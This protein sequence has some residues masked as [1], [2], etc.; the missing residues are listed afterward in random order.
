MKNTFLIM[1][2]LFSADGAFC[3]SGK[4]SGIVDD[5]YQISN[6]A[7]FQEIEDDLTAS[8]IL[9]N[10]ID[11]SETKT[12][13]IGKG[14][15]PLGS[16]EGSM[17]FTGRLDGN[18]FSIRNL[19]IN[20]PM[21][22]DL[23]VFYCISNGAEI[24]NLSILDAEVT[25][26]KNTA[27]FSSI[28]TASQN[29]EV[30]IQNC[31][32]SGSLSGQVFIAGFCYKISSAANG[33]IYISDCS[34]DCNIVGN[35]RIGGFCN[36]VSSGN[37]DASLTRI[38]DCIARGRV[39]GVYQVGGF[40]SWNISYDGTSEIEGCISETEVNCYRLGGGFCAMNETSG[41][42]RAVINQCVSKGNVIVSDDADIKSDYW[43]GGFAG[44]NQCRGNDSTSAVAEITECSSEGYVKGLKYTGGFVGDMLS[45]SGG[46]SL[47]SKCL[48][49]GRVEGLSF[50][51]GFCG[52]AFDP[53]SFPDELNKIIIS[54]C[55]STGDV[56]SN[57]AELRNTGGFIGKAKS[58]TKV[59]NCY[60]KGRVSGIENTAGFCGM[61]DEY[62]SIRNCYSIGSVTGEDNTGG[63]CGFSENIGQI[64]DS[65]WD[66]E[67]SGVSFSSGGTGRTRSEMMI[68]ASF[69]NWDFEEIWC[70][71]EGKSYPKLKAIEDCDPASTDSE[72]SENINISIYPNPFSQFL[73]INY[74]LRMADNVTFSLYN[75]LGNKAAVLF[76]G[77]KKAG[78]HQGVFNV[79]NTHACSLRAGVYFLRI[80]AGGEAA[81]QLIIK[82]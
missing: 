68:K 46:T 61:I 63:F 77:Y 36:W 19:S 71:S 70:L 26:A 23:G 24:M 64:N 42:G 80:E 51:G 8:Y 48:S 78:R 15:D 12:W 67:S 66:I 81:S 56:S 75:V 9:I 18:N 59:E 57:G 6:I 49:T 27:I 28:I 3:F 5:P 17:C 33:K 62:A 29:A 76:E 4:G 41:Y 2:L 50:S 16:P 22:M 35:V 30:N 14:F 72:G 52:M 40:C 58:Y 65:Y 21:E 47:I 74:E 45:M 7:E 31:H 73:F 79:G 82:N 10:D 20:R 38:Q 11:A 25:G 34:S 43:F 37:G 54:E 60:S 69:E 32:V 13:N 53:S 55:F 39:E 44:R 1:L